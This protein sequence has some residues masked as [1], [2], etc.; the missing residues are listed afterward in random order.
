VA[1]VSQA[2][3][4]EAIVARQLFVFVLIAM[5]ALAADITAP[6]PA[7]ANN[8]AAVSAGGL[9][10]CALTA[11]GGIQCWG[12][13]TVGELGD[14]TTATRSTPVD[15]FGL[16]SGMAAV[17][18]GYVD[19]C[20]VTTGGGVI[21]WGG[22]S[23]GELG[24]GIAGGYSS[25][26]VPVSG[27]ASAAAAV[28][29][30]GSHVCALTTG[31]AVK[32]WGFNGGGQLGNGSTTNSSSPVDVSGL[33]SGVAAVSA[34]GGY[35]CA[36]TTAGGVKCWGSNSAGQLGN[37]CCSDSSTP[38][39]V[40]GLTSGVAAIS[41][42][43]EH[44]CALTTGG[45]VK[46]WGRNLQGQLGN[47]TTTINSCDCIT[48]PVDVSGLTSG[49]AAV[50]AGQHHTCA[51][52]TGGGVKCWGGNGVG[53]LGNGTTTDSS[54]PV[55]VSGLTSGVAVVSAGDVHNCAVTTLGGA[56]CWGYNGY[57]QLG[58][59]TFTDS[60]SP[61]DVVGLGPK[62]VG[63]IT[64]LTDAARSQERTASHQSAAFPFVALALVGIS[65]A[66]GA[67]WL[68]RRQLR[69]HP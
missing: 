40:S 8:V 69:R 16:T 50:S 52:T 37:G 64:S 48:T 25:T 14:G 30:G 23:Y 46:C 42:G 28:S 3:S 26:P 56:K 29:V 22:N 5:V 49:V 43:A 13:N 47:G 27:L 60:H 62:S 7:H 67:I 34:G 65:S 4:G 9:H 6:E 35:T 58:N 63:G 41:A 21:C 31:G 59:S 12:Y 45:G 17:S 36:L 10:T 51:L 19:T 1:G 32:C 68:A 57:G 53:Q 39:N 20:A 66:A 54:T 15:V 33:T 18:A 55:D 2:C 38:V 24:Y 44:T 11:G 61:V